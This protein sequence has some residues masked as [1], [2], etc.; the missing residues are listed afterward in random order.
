M[1]GLSTF[2]NETFRMPVTG[3]LG[4]YMAKSL[5]D[6]GNHPV[7]GERLCSDKSIADDTVRRVADAAISRLH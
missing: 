4:D 6:K 3:S 5:I 1:L 2:A 7:P